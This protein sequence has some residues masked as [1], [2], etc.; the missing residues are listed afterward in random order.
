MTANTRENLREALCARPRLFRAPTFD[1][2]LLETIHRLAPHLDLSLDEPSRDFW[3]VQQN[4]ACWSEYDCLLPF[5]GGR[6]PSRVLEIGPGLGRSTIFFKRALKWEDVP[7][8]LYEG[9]GDTTRYTM[10]GPRV[11]D[12]FCGNLAELR[13][14]LAFNHVANVRVL[15]AR[16]P[17]AGFGDM[18]SDYSFV[19]GFYSIGFH[20]SIEHYADDI[21]R[22]LAPDG[23]AAFIA[24]PEFVVP[25]RLRQS[26]LDV[27]E[28]ETA[29]KKKRQKML[30][31]HGRIAS[32]P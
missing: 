15:D 30:V 21:D 10:L 5:I 16:G 20:W 31:F 14:V 18:P 2:A 6:M 11:P 1:R 28:F 9:D 27:V 17:H 13:R 3:E 23:I 26:A 19:Y 8:D 29:W 32:R 7:F 4:A 22:L 24:P 12:S 25:P